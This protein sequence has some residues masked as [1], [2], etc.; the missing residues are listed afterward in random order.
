MTAE[1][2]HSLCSIMFRIHSQLDQNNVSNSLLA[3]SDV[4][5]D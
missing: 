1:D 4:P 2:E 5:L 3:G